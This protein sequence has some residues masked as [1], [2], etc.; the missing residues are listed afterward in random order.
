MALRASEILCENQVDEV[1]VDSF[2]KTDSNLLV[3]GIADD[4]S[5]GLGRYHVGKNDDFSS[6]ALRESPSPNFL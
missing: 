4:V 1:L 6:V 2:V 5:V 3:K